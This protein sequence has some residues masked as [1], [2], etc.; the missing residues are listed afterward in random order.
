MSPD[1]GRRTRVPCNLRKRSRA[2]KPRDRLRA[3]PSRNGGREAVC[4]YLQVRGTQ[5]CIQ[6][7]SSDF[8]PS[9][10][11]YALLF[12]NARIGE[13]RVLPVYAQSRA[14]I[15]G[16]ALLIGL[17]IEGAMM[18]TAGELASVSGKLQRIPKLINVN[19]KVVHWRWQRWKESVVLAFRICSFGISPCLSSFP[20]GTFWQRAPGGFGGHGSLYKC[21]CEIKKEKFGVR[22]GIR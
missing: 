2:S 21:T 18:T 7:E 19:P 10:V 9:K 17:R 5:K 8:F 20:Y 14:S 22:G 4:V 6:E 3:R 13:I 12:P 16:S 1:T 11:P 15:G